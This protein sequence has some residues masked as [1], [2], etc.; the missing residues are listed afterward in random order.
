MPGL[1]DIIALRE[2]VNIRGTLITVRGISITTIGQCLA[3]SD[4]LQKFWAARKFDVVSLL[5]T[6]PR[7]LSRIVATAIVDDAPGPELAGFDED[8]TSAKASALVRYAKDAEAHRERIVA[9]NMA[10]F[11]SLNS[12]DQLT[13]VEAVVRVSFPGGLSPFVDR[14]GKLAGRDSLT[15]SLRA[16]YGKGQDG[17][18]PQPSSS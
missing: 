16:R 11:D 12:D 6:L 18:S 1:V 10:A 13:L 14:L 2:T 8:D 7:T 15:A 5:A 9:A 4:D 3:E 17:T